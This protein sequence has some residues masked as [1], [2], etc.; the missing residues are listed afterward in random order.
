MKIIINGAEKE[1][2]ESASLIQLI[3]TLGLD[4]GRVAIE[5]NR[6]IVRRTDWPTTTVK[7]GDVVEIVTFVGGGSQ[8]A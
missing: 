1:V 4:S 8:P 5:I 6:R 3:E 2:S 7:L